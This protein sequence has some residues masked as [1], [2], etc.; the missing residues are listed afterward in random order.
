MSGARAKPRR[1]EGAADAELFA[2]VAKHRRFARRDRL[3]MEELIRANA[4]YEDPSPPAALMVTAEDQ[5]LFM[6]CWRCP[7][8]K[9]ID[10]DALADLRKYLE[11]LKLQPALFRDKLVRRLRDRIIEMD[12]AGR[13]WV[14]AR[15]A[16]ARQ[17]GSARA[18]RRV[19]ALKAERFAL[20][21]AIGRTPARTAAGLAA[22]LSVALPDVAM[23]AEEFAD[24]SEIEFVL[25]SAVLDAAAI[26][27]AEALSYAGEAGGEVLASARSALALAGDASRRSP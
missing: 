21:R 5:D 20:Y 15:E 22:K 1:P 19:E 9:P 14:R 16:A 4:R 23:F 25:A 10:G 26:V 7:L 2:L 24:D 12:R 11:V 17:C 8:G 18:E 13:T 27:G 3:A 6:Q